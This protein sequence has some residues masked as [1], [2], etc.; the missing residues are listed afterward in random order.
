VVLSA[1]EIKRMLAALADRP[2]PKYWSKQSSASVGDDYYG[3]AHRYRM[4]PTATES[5]V[6]AFEQKHNVSL[7][8]DY[9]DFLLQIGNGGAGPAYGVFPLG[10][11]EDMALPDDM[12][13]TLRNPFDDAAAENWNED[14]SDP[15]W[16]WEAYPEV[17]QGAMMISTEGCALWYW[18]IVTGPS[19]G[20]IWFDART[21][22][23]PPKRLVDENGEPITFRSWF[24]SWLLDS[25]A[26]WLR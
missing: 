19:A 21:D 13:A 2:W 20:Q 23:H 18:L 7:P 22:G 12:L 26:K 9:R 16:D 11:Y 5:E 6:G 25:A 17:M 10:T 15:D 1:D 3:W 14:W 24:D 8:A 4:E